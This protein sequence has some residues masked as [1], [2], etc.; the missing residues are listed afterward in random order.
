MLLAFCTCKSD[1]PIKYKHCV[2][3]CFFAQSVKLC[4]TL[5][6]RTW[7][8]CC[9]PAGDAVT[10]M[11]SALREKLD[12]ACVQYVQ[13]CLG[14]VHINW[15]DFSLFY[16]LRHS[17][18]DLVYCMPRTHMLGILPALLWFTLAAYPAACLEQSHLSDYSMSCFPGESVLPAHT[19]CFS[20]TILVA[21]SNADS[22]IEK[23]IQSCA[24]K[25]LES[26]KR[27]HQSAAHQ[28]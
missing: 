27:Q 1:N 20:L 18:V 6:Y 23:K 5:I 21:P 4:S 9:H 11:L 8:S 3:V 25:Y 16:L 17:H 24:T 19:I 13:D 12:K 14:E 2:F 10:W 22:K 7:A 26:N 15:H 28:S